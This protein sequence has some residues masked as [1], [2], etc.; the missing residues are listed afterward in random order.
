M[1][2]IR[3]GRKVDVGAGTVTVD[4]VA[5]DTTTLDG[6]KAAVRIADQLLKL[7]DWYAANQPKL[8]RYHSEFSEG[9]AIRTFSPTGDALR[10]DELVN[11]LPHYHRAVDEFDKLHARVE[12][13]QKAATM[14]AYAFGAALILAVFAFLN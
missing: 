14:T 4:G 10:L 7:Q 2:D 12:S 11:Q 13:M 6:R 9:R 3:P 1:S 8:E 5:I